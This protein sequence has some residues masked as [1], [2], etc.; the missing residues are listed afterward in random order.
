MNRGKRFL[1]DGFFLILLVA[2]DQLTKGWAVAALKDQ[3]AI[4]LIPGIL[5]LKYLENTGAAFG[6]LQGAKLFFVAI[7]LIILA[8]IVFVLFR[9]PREK[10]Y[11]LLNLLLVLIAAGAIG[12]LIDRF[13]H[14]YVVDFIYASFID[15]PIFNVADIYVS[16]SAFFLVI[17]LLF[18]YHEEDFAFLKKG[19]DG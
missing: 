19:R 11:R 6:M 12:N 15:F 8:A 5:E 14:D 9:M 2:L 7:A 16:V 4:P 13:L 3:P 17:A 1:T 10:K 18:V